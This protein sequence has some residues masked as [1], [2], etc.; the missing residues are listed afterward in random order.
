MLAET[1]V[2]PDPYVEYWRE[3]IE[4]AM[5]EI[6]KFNALTP[7]EY[8]EVAHALRGAE[9]C[10]SMAFHTP[11]HPAVGELARLKRELATERQM[12]FCKPC[13]GTG[14][15]KYNAGPWGVNTECHHCHGEGKHL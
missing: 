14:R 6:G 13:Q 5:D 10:R 8:L 1:K 15:L 11:E 2:R 9:E 7:A 4:C 12:V 3:A